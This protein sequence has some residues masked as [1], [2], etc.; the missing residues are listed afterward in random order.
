MLHFSSPSICTPFG[1][2]LFASILLAVGAAPM[3][4]SC[5]GGQNAARGGGQETLLAYSYGGGMDTYQDGDR[6]GYRVEIRGNGEYALYERIYRR[7]EDGGT[8]QNDRINQG[9]L[10]G[11]VFDS[12]K[13]LIR[14]SDFSSLPD[15]L[16]N[17]DPRKTEIRGPA[18]EVYLS[19][20]TEQSRRH[21]TRAHM[22]ADPEHY[23]D[24]FLRLHRKLKQ[25]IREE[26]IDASR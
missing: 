26:L 12:L 24:T 25:L 16:P 13:T 20:R 6:Y 7:S 19:V 3:A 9:T 4:V 14:T 23:P 5:Q 2:L 22:G 21:T 17:V 18:E 15:R 8:L 10:Q 1:R 11:E